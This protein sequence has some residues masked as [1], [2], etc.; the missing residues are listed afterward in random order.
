MAILG[1]RFYLGVIPMRRVLALNVVAALS[2]LGCDPSTPATDAGADA[3]LLSDAG[4]DPSAEDASAGDAG[5][6]DAGATDAGGD[7]GPVSRSYT[8]RFRAEVGGEAFACG[9]TY[10]GF[11]PAADRSVTLTDFRFY[12]HQVELLAADGSA[13]PLAITDDGTFQADDVA[14]LDFEDGGP[15][16]MG[17][18]ETHTAITGTALEGAYTGIRF[19]LGIPFSLNHQDASA[20]HAPFNFTSMFWNWQG[21][22]KFVRIDAINVVP[23]GGGSLF[24]VHLGS[25]GC[26]GSPAGGVTMCDRPNRSTIELTG[27]DPETSV[28]V[29][30]FAELM[31]GVDP[32]INTAATAPGCMSGATDPECNEVVPSFGIPFGAQPAAMDFFSVSAP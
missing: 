9:T 13:T 12:V 2:M 7:G 20:A 25:T 5:A 29:A 32:T 11:G 19:V 16:T 3:P 22:Y 14:L 28:V 1:R 27:F 8:I 24:A 15:C 4:R 21:G 23:G 10:D 6:E 17:T 30:D 31:E 26:D 18:T